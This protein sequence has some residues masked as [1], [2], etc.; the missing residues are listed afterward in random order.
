MDTQSLTLPI[1]RN[2]LGKKIVDI[3]VKTYVFGCILFALNKT[4]HMKVS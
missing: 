2:F 1:E 4:G 3:V